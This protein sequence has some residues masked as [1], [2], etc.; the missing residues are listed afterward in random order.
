MPNLPN[1][2]TPPLSNC[3]RQANTKH[4]IRF[5]P[6]QTVFS[7]TE[8][9]ATPMPN[10]RRQENITATQGGSG[11]EHGLPS[12]APRA[13]HLQQSQHEYE[14]HMKNRVNVTL[15]PET[16]DVITELAELRG[17]TRSSLIREFLAA[18]VPTL[19]TTIEMMKTINNTDPDKM[20]AIAKMLEEADLSMTEM[21]ELLAK[22]TGSE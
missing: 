4:R 21:M 10:G 3:V 12:P 20:A 9:T 6:C 8:P 14:A 18:S 17:L 1:P 15:T 11:S 5:A 19:Q 22:R 16:Y 13:I 2:P 7:Y